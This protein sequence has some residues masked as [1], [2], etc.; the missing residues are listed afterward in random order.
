MLGEQRLT[1]RRAVGD[2][3][4]VDIEARE[5]VNHQLADRHVIIDDQRA[6]APALVVFR[7]IRRGHLGVVH[8]AVHLPVG[9]QPQK[10]GCEVVVSA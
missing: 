9:R 8:E 6:N 1:H 5:V 10:M 7:L 3:A 2:A 4:G